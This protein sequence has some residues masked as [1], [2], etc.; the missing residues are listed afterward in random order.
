MQNMLHFDRFYDRRRI[1]MRQN[2]TSI[3]QKML[4][5]VSGAVLT[6]SA[7]GVLPAAGFSVLEPE[8]MP[9][10][11][12]LT[13]LGTTTL[14][15]GKFEPIQVWVA[16]LED[17]DTF[18][19]TANESCAAQE[20]NID[21]VQEGYSVRRD[22]FAEMSKTDANAIVALGD[23]AFR[24]S[25]AQPDKKED[26]DFSVQM[27]KISASVTK[28]YDPDFIPANLRK[29]ENQELTIRLFGSDEEPDPV[30]TEKSIVLSQADFFTQAAPD[31]F[32]VTKGMFGFADISVD[33]GEGFRQTKAKPYLDTKFT[34]FA[35]NLIGDTYQ[36]ENLI[37]T[38]SSTSEQLAANWENGAFRTIRAFT[39]V[40][41]HLPPLSRMS[42]RFDQELKSDSFFRM[43]LGGC[44]VVSKDYDTF[45]IAVNDVSADEVCVKYSVLNP[46]DYS[47]LSSGESSLTLTNGKGEQRLTDI[48]AP[49]GSIIV[50]D[51]MDTVK[52]Q[53][54]QRVLTPCYS[55]SVRLRGIQ[56][57]TAEQT[58]QT[59][60]PETEKLLPG[61]ADCSG[62]IDVSDAVMLARYVAEDS[63]VRITETG[64]RNADCNKNGN[65]DSEDVILIL[66]YIAKLIPQIG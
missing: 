3:L 48:Q 65:P 17:F 10:E 30:L 36:I 57:L 7:A 39:E 51:A 55:G 35:S 22:C 8:K 1:T 45:E 61:D 13:L 46:S 28:P 47:V 32:I 59:Q 23:A 63:D 52:M 27:L 24:F 50:I 9:A 54:D 4:A 18:Y 42:L 11:D 5:V 41:N 40:N 58:E 26:S 2:F 12:T 6:V 44:A 38:S 25:L 29:P 14:K 43:K 49:T 56:T 62:V 19:V 15:D 34:S 16:S 66:Q 60:Q 64:K 21:I 33:C 37:S 20:I 31:A 53:D